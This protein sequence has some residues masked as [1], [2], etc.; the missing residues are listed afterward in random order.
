MEALYLNSVIQTVSSGCFSVLRVDRWAE[1]TAGEGDDQRV[2]SLRHGH[3]PQHGDE[4]PPPRLGKHSDPRR[5]SPYT[6]RAEQ[7]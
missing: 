1:R 6:Q 3:S 7:L 4:A 2:H 5:S